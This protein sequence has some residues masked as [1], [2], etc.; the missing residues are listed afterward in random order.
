MPHSN[1]AALAQPSERSTTQ[2]VQILHL[3]APPDVKSGDLLPAAIGLTLLVLFT[4]GLG[5][6]DTVIA[7]RCLAASWIGFLLYFCS[8]VGRHLPER[9]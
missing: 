3:L 4:L 8:S 9:W 7:S 2:R 6:S 1:C 5:H